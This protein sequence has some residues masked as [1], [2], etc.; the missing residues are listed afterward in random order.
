MLRLRLG[1]R[2][3][4]FSRSGSSSQFTA[5]LP[6][7]VPKPE[8][9]PIPAPVHMKR[10][11]AD[12]IASAA[13]VKTASVDS[14]IGGG[15]GSASAS[16]AMEIVS[17]SAVFEGDSF[18]VEPVSGVSF[19]GAVAVSAGLIL[20]SDS[21]KGEFVTSIAFDVVEWLTLTLA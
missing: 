2:I 18:D 3:L 4:I 8:S 5:F 6:R 7:N 10:A 19:V 17:G 14:G 9:T 11:S 12:A 13:A 1:L 16:D 15:G 20:D 21:F